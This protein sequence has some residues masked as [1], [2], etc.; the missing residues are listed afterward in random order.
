MSKDE[1]AEGGSYSTSGSAIAGLGVFA[2]AVAFILRLL[3][4]E[5]HFIDGR[6]M[7]LIGVGFVVLGGGMA[8]YGF[9]QSKK[10]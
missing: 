8:I 3:H 1:E 4:V 5:L 7:S 10:P 9:A 6:A 2:L